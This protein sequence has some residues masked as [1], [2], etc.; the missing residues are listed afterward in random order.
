[1]CD[2]PELVDVASQGDSCMDFLPEP[3]GGPRFRQCDPGNVI[4]DY[5]TGIW[6]EIED[7]LD[8]RNGDVCVVVNEILS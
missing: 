4:H 7:V 3:H 5:D 6:I 1:M 2:G 8:R